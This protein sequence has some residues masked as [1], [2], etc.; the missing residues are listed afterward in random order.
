[1]VICQT[2]FRVSF[3]GGG[4]DY[5][6][7]YL[8]HGGSVLSTAINKYGYI[9]CRHLPPFF[10][11]KHRVVYSKI[12]LVKDRSE[13]LHPAVRAA[14][15]YMDVEDG[16]EIHYDGDIPSQSGIGSSSSFTVGLLNAMHALRGEMTS[17]L[18]LAEEAI[19]VEQNVI[20]ETVGSQDQIAAAFGGLNRINFFPNGKFEVRP[21]IIPRARAQDLENHMLLF[22][23]G[24]SRIAQT[25]AKSK[26]ENFD[27]RQPHLY[28]M[29]KM[30]DEAQEILQSPRAD[31]KDFGRMLHDSWLLKRDL[32][33]KVSNPQIDELYET[34]L[35]AGAV[36]GKILGAGGGGFLLL[37]A[38]PEHHESI[39][40]KL[41]SL[42]EVPFKFE[43]QGSQIIL[44]NP[45]HNLPA[46]MSSRSRKTGTR[47]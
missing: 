10:Q 21:V 27:Q 17:K 9:T 22:F 7:W 25:I 5:P 28:R 29:M 19:H 18:A 26:I 46:L 34:G 16:L 41:S 36:G 13:I 33:D 14:F 3:F 31:L 1:M 43:H 39:R 12:E 11:Y 15:D 40:Q 44:Y 23:T 20:G 32:S 2:P 47:K 35:R 30:V 4:T 24:F 45:S 6:V 8:Q 38:S 37:F 42:I